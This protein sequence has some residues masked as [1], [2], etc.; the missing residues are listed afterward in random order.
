MFWQI[1]GGEFIYFFINYFLY[2]L[3]KKDKGYLVSLIISIF[4]RL[5]KMQMV[6]EMQIQLHVEGQECKNLLKHGNM[7]EYNANEL[8]H[9]ASA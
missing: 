5:N 4:L 7:V 1:G 9:F 2:G 6:L 3:E 8:I